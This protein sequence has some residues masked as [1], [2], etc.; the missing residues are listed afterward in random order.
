MEN[1]QLFTDGSYQADE[2]IA[3]IGGYLLDPKNKV[4]F[5]FYQQIEEPAHY[6]YH[7]S[8]ALI[9]GLNKALEHGVEH[10]ECFS[11]DA[12]MR[13]ILN[14][15]ILSNP[16]SQTNPFREEIFELKK[17]F[18][19][20]FFNHLPRKQ[21]RKA[22]KLAGKI[23]RIYKEEL[24]PYRSRSHFIGQED[25]FLSL[26]NLICEEDFQEGIKNISTPESFQAIEKAQSEMRNYIFVG[27]YKDAE[28]IDNID[29]NNPIKVNIYFVQT[30]NEKRIEYFHLISSTVMIQRKLISFG[31]DFLADAFNEVSTQHKDIG[32]IFDTHIQPLRKLEMLF[33]KRNI[34]PLPDTP[35]TRKF[36]ASNKFDKIVLHNDADIIN[37]L[38]HALSA[39]YSKKVVKSKKL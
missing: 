23:L 31:L 7:E 9:H 10:L 8:I 39:D 28:T 1:Y 16:S 24:T 15:D 36:M 38:N 5:E 35:L 4:V 30:D 33:R 2:K 32:L 13:R 21:N 11:D 34:L 3:A 12:S 22:D 20:I 26:P 27:V 37:S 25:K 14:K 17:K 18:K 6:M 29:D 19:S